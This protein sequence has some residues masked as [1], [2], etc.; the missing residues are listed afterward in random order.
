M[1]IDI[2]HPRRKHLTTDLPVVGI[3]GVVATRIGSN[4]VP[5]PGARAQTLLVALA[6]APGRRRAAQA[7]IDEVWPGEP[8]RSPKNALQTQISRLR[9]VLPAGVV[10]SDRGGYRLALDAEDTDLGRARVHTRAAEGRLAS[11]EWQD[12]LDGV[13]DALS[14]WRGEPAESVRVQAELLEVALRSVQIAALLGLRRFD[15]AIPLAR[16][17]VTADPT[18][19]FA[20]ADLMRAL[21]GAGRSNDALTVFVVLRTEL[22]ERLGTDPSPAVTA[23]NTEI[24]GHTAPKMLQTIG[25]RAA[26]NALIGRGDDVDAIEALLGSSRVTTVLGPGGAGKTRIAHELGRRAA[27]HM[28]VAFVELASLRSEEDVASAIGATLGLTE[29]DVKVGGL[30]VTRIHSIRERLV[31]VFSTRRGL[32]ILDNCEHVID[33][34]AVVVDALV[35]STDAVTVLATSRSPMGITAESVFPLPSLGVTGSNSPATELF[36]I[37]ARAVRPSAR[38][39]PDAVARLCRTLDGLPLA[40]ELAAARVKS[41]SVEEIDARLDRRFTLLRSADRTRPERHRTLHAVIDWSW[42]LLDATEQAALRRLCRFP[43]GFDLDAA[44]RV[45]QWAAVEDVSA[46]LDGLVNQSMLSVVET[47]IGIRYHMLETV[48]EY[49][50]EQLDASGEA[51]A[52]AARL[53]EWSTSVAV[54]VSAGYS[55]GRPAEM[56]ALMEAEHDNLLSVMRH[57]LEQQFSDNVCTLFSVLGYFWAMRG[58]HS[59]VLNWADRVQT[60][61][62][63]GM[64]GTPDDNAAM[65]L[66]VLAAHYAYGGNLRRIA[67]IRVDLRRLLHGRA[68]ISPGLRFN[69]EVLVHHAGG[70]GVARKLALAIR[71]EHDDVRCNAYVVRSMLAQ[72]SGRLYESIRDGEQALVIARRRGDLWAVGSTSQTLASS[73]GLAGDHARAVEY[74]RISADVMWEMH[75]FEESMQTRT[76]LAMALIGAGRVDEGR[77]LIDEL[78]A[79]AQGQEITLDPPS[80]ND[81]G[82]RWDR[83]Q[84]RSSSASLT[85]AR[86]AADIEDGAVEQG[87]EGFRG[88]LALGGWPSEDP[89]DP[90]MTILVCAGVGA[91]V[92]HGRAEDMADAVAALTRKPWNVLVPGGFYDIP[93]L[94][95]VACAVGSFEI[96]S[97]DRALGAQLLAVSKKAVGRQDFPT[98]RIDRHLSAARAIAGD[99]EVDAGLARAAVFTRNGALQEILRLLPLV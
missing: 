25:L 73:Y 33:E 39:E 22:A 44:R 55:G 6:L 74:Y 80:D 86:A 91:H 45:A 37:R 68:G 70:R 28:S 7:L 78:E 5:V 66:L 71:S 26:P 53:R 51:R 52:V 56:V 75:A 61:M 47:P 17:R 18:D 69:S 10:E 15:D 64:L 89:S 65:T 9:S 96:H 31:D 62:R 27:A 38:L 32:L 81:I 11:S 36:C 43:A 19:E 59:E 67:R 20:T 13:L 79:V 34:V 46:A 24:L 4:L 93:M 99:R 84:Q 48:R 29:A 94:G 58:A 88:A 85:A 42:N 14:L 97:G 60:S 95:A 21:H 30:Q 16:A 98:M 54:R 35:A 92:L 41:M 72:N 40:I 50:E 77:G 57:S 49:G 12:A 83:A 87:L 2:A 90:F 8:P 23:L 3:L 82:A 76:F 1:P 63:G